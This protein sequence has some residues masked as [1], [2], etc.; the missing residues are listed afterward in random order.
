MCP[1][2]YGR[3]GAFLTTA[4]IYLAFQFGGI[5]AMIDLALA[6]N[7][8]GIA[9]AVGAVLGVGNLFVGISEAL[10]H[11]DGFEAGSVIFSGGVIGLA[12]W[13]LEHHWYLSGGPVWLHLSRAAW[14]GLIGSEVFNIWL[15]LRNIARRGR[16][17]G[18]YDT[19]PVPVEQP[20]RLR[21]RRSIEWV[22]EIEGNGVEAHHL[23]THDHP[24]SNTHFPEI[25]H[26]A[27]P[28]I[29]YVKDR[30]GDFIPVQLPDA[31]PVSRRL[32]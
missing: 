10:S 29:V 8:I 9:W 2:N 3:L 21:R 13:G 19:N 4:A 32:R 12:A 31:V 15:N 14:F 6:G 18:S 24:G 20:R 30:N 5:A 16:E 27:A 23:I 11:D 7:I 1:C 28:Q 22:E 25:D 26:E 17:F